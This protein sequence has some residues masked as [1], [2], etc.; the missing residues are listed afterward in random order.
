MK[1]KV[2]VPSIEEQKAI[3]TILGVYDKEIKLLQKQVTNL[4]QQKKGLI[5]RLLTGKIRIKAEKFS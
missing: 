2:F 3:A 1:I 5:Q 4:R